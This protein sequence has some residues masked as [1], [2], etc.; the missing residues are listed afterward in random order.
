MRRFV[1]R[2]RQ[3]QVVVTQ[4]A[5]PLVP[6][7]DENATL[8][9]TL[10]CWA[11]RK[12]QMCLNNSSGKFWN[13]T[14]RRQN[15]FL[16]RRY[17][18]VAAQCVCSLSYAGCKTRVPYYIVWFYQIFLHYKK[19]HNFRG[20]KLL[21]IKCVL[22]FSTTTV[23]NI[24][25]SKKNWNITTAPGLHVQ[26]RY[27]YQMWMKLKCPPSHQ[28]LWISSNFSPFFPCGLTDRQTD[29]E[30]YMMKH[31]L[32]FMVAPCINNFEHFIVQLMHTNYR[33]FR[34]LKKS[35]L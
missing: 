14:V 23:W 29:R 21:N 26:Y 4:A 9:E 25:H 28:I 35:K 15:T 6:R 27:S 17:A 22:M 3:E 31:Q 11:E 7:T 30:T 1:W 10:I 34:L 16:L 33:I 20:K 32:N 5:S 24:C 13:T 2:G 19:R 18:T 8:T 12:L